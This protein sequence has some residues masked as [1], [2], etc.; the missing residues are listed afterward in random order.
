MCY[1]SA[2]FTS[3]N[4]CL[5]VTVN[6]ARSYFASTVRYNFLTGFSQRINTSL[7]FRRYHSHPI[8][9]C[10]SVRRYFGCTACQPHSDKDTLAWSLALKP[11]YQRTS[12]CNTNWVLPIGNIFLPVLQVYGSLHRDGWRLV[13]VGLKVIYSVGENQ[14]NRNGNITCPN[15][16]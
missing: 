5:F 3:H 7:S 6:P 9:Q 12:F 2:V 15:A 10:F 1:R 14:K 4:T 11:A 8:L 16:T 13:Q